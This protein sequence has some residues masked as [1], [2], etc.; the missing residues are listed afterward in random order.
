MPPKANYNFTSTHFQRSVG[1]VHLP[2]WKDFLAYVHE[3][4]SIVPDLVWRGQCCESWPLQPSLDREFKALRMDPFSDEAAA[5]VRFEHLRRFKLAARGRLNPQ[6]LE[7]RVRLDDLTSSDEGEPP[8][9]SNENAPLGPTHKE[10]EQNNWWA[11]GQHHGLSTPLLD[12]TASPFVAAFFAFAEELRSCDN[13][14]G[15][16]IYGLNRPLVAQ[17]SDE[18]REKDIGSARPPVVDFVEPLYRDNPRLVSQGGLFT[19]SPNGQGL[20]EWV[21]ENYNDED[22]DYVLLLKLVLPNKNREYILRSLNAMNINH[23]SL[24]PDLYG[25]TEFVNFKLR[26]DDY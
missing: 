25:A 17:K 19:R 26:I 10:R 15:R 22:E 24:F 9:G 20:A 7:E 12:W 21:E 6:E 13:S 16:A 5:T 2:T 8:N 14:E 23:Q 11:V 4:L 3:N 1:E 18:I